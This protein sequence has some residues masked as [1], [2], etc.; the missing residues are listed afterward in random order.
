MNKPVYF[1][2]IVTF[3]FFSR[4]TFV[5][6]KKCQLAFL[7]SKSLNFYLIFLWSWIDL[8]LKNRINCRALTLSLFNMAKVVKLLIKQTVPGGSECKTKCVHS[9]R[10]EYHGG[11][12]YLCLSPSA[13]FFGVY[14]MLPLP[15]H[16]ALSSFTLMALPLLIWELTEARCTVLLIYVF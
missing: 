14:V 9:I 4:N 1:G 7:E 2:L 13:Y 16:A 8:W 12:A 6:I 3:F 10:G 11:V 5:I 15:C